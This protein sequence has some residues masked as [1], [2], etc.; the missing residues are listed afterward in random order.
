LLDII[1]ATVREFLDDD[2]PRLA[3]ALSYYTV[4]SLPAILILILLVTGFFT[5]AD[6]VA[7]RIVGETQDVLGEE[8]ATQIETMIREAGDLG[9]GG[10]ATLLTLAA[11]AFGATGA[12]FQLQMALNKA[13]NVAPDPDS[14]IKDF[15]LKRALSFGMVLAI[16]FLLLVSLALSALLTRAGAEIAQLLPGVLSSGLLLAIDVGLSLAVIT[17]LFAAIF[18]VMPDAEITWRDV[19][20][21]ALVTAVIF[22]VLKYLFGYFLSLADPGS[23]FGAAGSLAIIM[24]W[25]YFASMVLFLGAEFTQV[26]ARKHGKRIQPS[27]G[28]VR[29]V[30]ES[31]ESRRVELKAGGAE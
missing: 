14:G 27:K 20:I 13:W 29:L 9:G 22:I 26:W 19:G 3:A 2:A 8:G 24:V 17:V 6:A 21:G 4:F 31:R 23:S 10:L 5:D 1:K 18:K 11:L 28:A 15:A 16:A 12:F 7:D 30:K 25:V